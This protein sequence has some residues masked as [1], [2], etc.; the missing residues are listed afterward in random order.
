M[1]DHIGYRGSAEQS[2]GRA[3]HLKTKKGTTSAPRQNTTEADEDRGGWAWFDDK[4]LEWRKANKRNH[5][6][7]VDS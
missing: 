7:K 3:S 2:G 5:P 4:L 1:Q 6:P